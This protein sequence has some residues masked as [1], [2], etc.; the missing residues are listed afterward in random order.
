MFNYVI[1]SKYGYPIF[2]AVAIAAAAGLLQTFVLVAFGVTFESNIMILMVS[3][4][5]MA[6]AVYAV[7]SSWNGLPSGW[8]ISRFWAGLFTLCYIGYERPGIDKVPYLIL[9]I[10]GALIGTIVAIN[11]TL[12]ASA[13][14]YATIVMVTMIAFV[15][16]PAIG[17]LSYGIGYLFGGKRQRRL[18]AEEAA[19]LEGRQR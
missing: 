19:E 9:A 8:N 12:I 18:A 15:A 6:I 2:L 17:L 13:G 16:Y 14:T 10:G 11:Q 5:Q 3:V 4:A 7:G 1:D